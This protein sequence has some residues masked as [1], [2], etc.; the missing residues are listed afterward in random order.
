MIL[1]GIGGPDNN[2]SRLSLLSNVIIEALAYVVARRGVEFYLKPQHEARKEKT[3]CVLF[4][5]LLKRRS[6]PSLG[7]GQSELRR[8][9]REENR[10]MGK[11]EERRTFRGMFRGLE[12]EI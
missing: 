9:S 10:K 4:F 3:E 12:D 2:N 7:L 6:A 1:S 8:P 5:I 11:S